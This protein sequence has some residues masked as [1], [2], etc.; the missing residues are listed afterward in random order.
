MR[1]GDPTHRRMGPTNAPPAGLAPARTRLK[2]EALVSLHSVAKVGCSRSVALRSSGSQPDTL[3]LEL[4]A[5]FEMADDGGHAPHARGAR[6]G[7]KAALGLAQF[8]IQKMA[9]A[10]GFAPTTLSLTGSRAT[11]A[12]RWSWR[13]RR[14][15]PSLCLPLDRRASMLLD[16]LP[17]K[18]VRQVGNAPT[19][20]RWSPGLQSGRPL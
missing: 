9:P 17:K 14:V 10:V 19:L 6:A 11:V 1:T 2:G 3:L 13:V 18:M 5:P 4:R 16:F 20:D 8:V 12:P 7:F 15:L